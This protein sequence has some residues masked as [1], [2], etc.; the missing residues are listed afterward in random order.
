MTQ[1]DDQKREALRAVASDLRGT[2]ASVE[3]ERLA[4][5]LMRA[6]D[7]YDEEIDTS[8][9]SIYQNMR[10]ILEIAERGGRDV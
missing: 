7:L 2:D 3:A 10:T 4:A 1:S 9:E 5:I 6:S 8:P